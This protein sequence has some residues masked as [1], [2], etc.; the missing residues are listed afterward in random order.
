MADVDALVLGSVNASWRRRIDAPTL[1]ACLSGEDAGADWEVHV[2]TFF[3]DVPREAVLRFLLA[4]DV[5]AAAAL[6]VYR[7]HFSPDERNHDGIDA[8][9]AELAD[10]A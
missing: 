5:T 3:E 7:K 1:A 6:A 4:H 9:L 8:W 2:R 10:A